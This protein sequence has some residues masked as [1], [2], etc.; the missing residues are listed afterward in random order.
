MSSILVFYD[1]M[2]EERRGS[3]LLVNTLTMVGGRILPRTEP[4]PLQLWAELPEHQRGI[5]AIGHPYARLVSQ[6]RGG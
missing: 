5:L 6:V 1:V 2:M 3:Q 4:S